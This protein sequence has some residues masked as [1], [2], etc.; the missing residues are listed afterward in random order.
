MLAIKGGRII[1][2][3]GPD[4]PSGNVLIENGKIVAVGKVDIPAGAQV[5]D[6][7][8][9]V[10]MPGILDAHAHIGVHEDGIGW[11]GADGNEAV[12]P[13][14]PQLRSL[15]GINPHDIAFLDARA[16]G[17]TACTSAPG[18]A[19]VIG[20][21][22]VVIKTCG[23]VIGDMLVRTWG[24]KAA[25]GE[26]PKRVYKDQKKMPSTRMGTAGLLR[27]T[28]VKAQNYQK[29]VLLG[30]KDP[31]KA[32][33]RDLKMEAMTK[34]LRGESVLRCHAHRAD[35]M[36]TAIRIAEE[37]KIK[38]SIEH[39][40]E[41]HKIAAYLAEKAIPC[42]VGPSFG[43]RTKLELKDKTFETAAILAKAGVKIA[44]MT[45]HP[46]I[47]MQYLPMCAA[48]AVRSGLPEREA[49]K[50]ITINSAEIMGVADRLGS[51]EPGKDGDV[52]VLD[53]DLFEMAT[54]VL[55]TVIDGK[56]VYSK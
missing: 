34:V 49:L 24:M 11:E 31:D 35:D 36:V 23:N 12:D 43:T 13:V 46:V 8:G 27:E 44:L 38:I 21:E 2:M 39:A 5:I 1:T 4:I 30:E 37:F 3:A 56:V 16:A 50:A 18:S 33:D 20:G 51:L 17:I 29:K 54:N 52:I 41:G 48:L 7:T 22:G 42:V 45:D 40:T 15:D 53:G 26:N 9:K 28:L 14:T 25:F 6:A 19:N 10:V 47:P 32:P 55:Y